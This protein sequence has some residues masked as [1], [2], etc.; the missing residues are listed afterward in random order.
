MKKLTNCSANKKA[1]IRNTPC[2]NT[3]QIKLCIII[4]LVR[5]YFFKIKFKPKAAWVT[6]IYVY[7]TTPKRLKNNQYTNRP[8]RATSISPASQKVAIITMLHKNYKILEEPNCD[9]LGSDSITIQPMSL[10]LADFNK[11]N[12]ALMIP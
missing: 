8:I 5:I 4:S 12:F 1:M 10:I 9:I 2:I 3:D 7:I 6:Y 11:L